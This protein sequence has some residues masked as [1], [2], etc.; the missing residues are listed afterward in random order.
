MYEL[1]GGESYT[2]TSNGRTS[3]EVANGIY[4]LGVIADYKNGRSETNEDNNVSVA[5]ETLQVE[6]ATVTLIEQPESVE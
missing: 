3:A 2:R 6:D 5:G 4:Y 1:K